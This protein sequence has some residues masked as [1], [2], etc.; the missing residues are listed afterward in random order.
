MGC[1]F[2][3]VLIVALLSFCIFADCKTVSFNAKWT[4]K[5]GSSESSLI[6]EMKFGNPPQ[7][8]MME[9]GL[10]LKVDGIE[11]AF[12]IPSYKCRQCTAA[13]RFYE[14]NSTTSFDE[15]D[16]SAKCSYSSRLFGDIYSD[17]IRFNKFETKQFQAFVV[18]TLDYCRV[19]NNPR[20]DGVMTFY[21]WGRL[22]REEL[23][24]LSLYD[25]NVI[26]E[27]WFTISS[28]NNDELTFTMGKLPNAAHINWLK[29]G[30]NIA[31]FVEKPN[32]PK[33]HAS[34]GYLKFDVSSIGFL[35]GQ[36]VASGPEEDVNKIYEVINAKEGSDIYRV[37]DCANYHSLPPLLFNV[38]NFG[39]ISVYPEDYIFKN[40]DEC[41]VLLFALEDPGVWHFGSSVF[42]RNGVVMDLESQRVGLFERNQEIDEFFKEQY[43]LANK[44]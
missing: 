6:T 38:G 3:L 31:W 33:S 2:T 39:M 11:R 12:A 41:I 35:L 14:T 40:K 25:N 19:F 34:F 4:E 18:D 42:K 37:V 29:V 32:L 9:I 15:G 43:M 30:E 22:K 24:P 28:I 17:T 44:Q 10:H 5:I 16:S 1:N 21:P 20:F 7:K 23:L 36:L 26:D 13:N 27:P 8:F